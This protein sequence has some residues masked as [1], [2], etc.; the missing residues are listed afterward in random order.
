MTVAVSET[1]PPFS[2]FYG[3]LGAACAII[4]ASVLYISSISNLIFYLI[5]ILALH[6][7]QLPLE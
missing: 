2:T 3:Y 4:F 7:V 6:T 1:C 5:Q